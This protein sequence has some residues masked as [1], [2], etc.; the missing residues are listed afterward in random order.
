MTDRELLE[1]AAKAAGYEVEES[2]VGG[3]K[4]LYREG[5]LVPWNPLENDGD[6]FRLAMDLRMICQMN[7]YYQVEHEISAYWAARGKFGKVAAMSLAEEFKGN[8]LA[9]QRRAI[10][11]VAAEI[12]KGM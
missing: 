2:S 1:L 8:F 12:G 3:E 9:A 5:E 10:V 11:M 7:E 4:N 6:A